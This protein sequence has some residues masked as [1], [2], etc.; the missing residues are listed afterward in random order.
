MRTRRSGIANLVGAVFFILIVVLM[1]GALAAM[2]GTFNSFIDGQHNSAQT[3]QQAQQ[4]SLNVQNLTYGGLT[5]Y[6]GF[7]YDASGTVTLNANTLQQPLLPITNMNFTSGM[8]GWTTSHTYKVVTDTATVQLSPQDITYNNTYPS[9][10]DSSP[11]SLTFSLNVINNNAAGSPYQIA[12]V[13]LL[14]DQNWGVPTPQ[15]VI[16]NWGATPLATSPPSVVG[17]N[18]TWLSS[19]PFDIGAGANQIF[20]WTA[21]VP[22]TYGTF[23]DTVIVSWLKNNAAPY[24]DSGI[25]TTNSTVGQTEVSDSGTLG[26]SIAYINPAPLG[27]ASSG[28]TAGYDSNA[29]TTSSL[30]GPGSLYLNFAPSA[31]SVPITDG[32]QLTATTTFTTSF[33]LD[34]ATTQDIATAGCC[35][36]TWE[37]NF[38]SVSSARNS[39]IVYQAYLTS[40]PIPGYPNGIIEALPIGGTS[41][42]SSPSSYDYLNPTAVNN[43]GSTG[44][45]LDKVCFNPSTVI[46]AWLNAGGHWYTGTYTLQI[47]VTTTMPGSLPQTAGYPPQISINLDDIGL[48]FKQTATTYYGTS[49]FQIPTGLNF[50][51]IQG[52]EV[53]INATG[54]N[55][56]TTIYAY[57]TD[58]SRPEFSPLDWVQIGSASFVNSG[59]ID[60][61][62]GLPNA[63]YYVNTTS[64]TQ[65]GKP[66]VGDLVVRV[67]ATSSVATA[68]YAVNLQVYAVIQ[69]FNQTRIAVE[70]QNQSPT[71]IRLLSMVITGPG[72][73]L[74]VP[75]SPTVPYFYIGS[76]EKIV[77]PETFTWIPGQTYTVTV[78]TAS[79]L[80][81]SS[82][83]AAPLA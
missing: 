71:P 66:E 59:V 41:C 20:T 69:T 24:I 72:A 3:T 31:N 42:G 2:F 17:N 48:A 68:P 15:P 70:L 63:A 46:P 12:K 56:N 74:T 43:F 65:G 44:W 58:N 80:T 9:T 13:S 14:V 34:T 62:N 18:I 11:T 10:T 32:Q 51:Q 6:N 82:S 5:S 38:D 23:Y 47:V 81:F 76:G 22:Q 30:S 4:A 73:A 39:L 16:F 49:T 52:M 78:T 57:V 28:L 8:E 33:A 27:T 83:F 54:A 21:S 37:S 50:N 61:V 55:Q 53:G 40:P 36:L 77:L 7:S 29:L 25:A 64:H 35:S 75:F 79:G 60:S 19:L 67:N 45:L 1:V 26:T